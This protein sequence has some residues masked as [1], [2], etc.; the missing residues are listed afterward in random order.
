MNHEKN[1]QIFVAASKIESP[2]LNKSAGR[3]RVILNNILRGM[4]AAGFKIAALPSG[5]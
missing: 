1:S 2:F 4:R 5:S 3:F